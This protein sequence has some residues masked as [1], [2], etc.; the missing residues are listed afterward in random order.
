MEQLLVLA[1]VLG[2][3]VAIWI[4]SRPKKKARDVA[5]LRRELAHLT[6]DDTAAQRLV[7]AEQ[8]RLPDA[9]EK[10][11][12]ERVIRRLRYERRR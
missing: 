9:T 8:Q 11:L 1:A 4:A 2:A 6:H 3:C 10:E 5:A 7:E 12:L